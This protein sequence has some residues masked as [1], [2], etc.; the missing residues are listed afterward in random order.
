MKRLSI[1][2][3]GVLL[4]IGLS[5]CAENP[6]YTQ[7]VFNDF[8]INP[9]IA[10]THDY[11]QIRSVDRFQWIGVENAPKT[12]ILSA[13][14]PHKSQ[15]M[16]W[17]G[18]LYLDTQGPTQTLGGYG[19][20]GYNITLKDDIHLSF[21]L[22]FGIIQYS[23]D[24]NKID[25]LNEPE[26]LATLSSNKY[27]KWTPDA[28][29]GTYLY[30]TQYYAGVSVDQLFNNKI[31]IERVDS[32]FVKGDKALNRLKSNFVLF[33]GYKFN[34]NRDF[35]MEPSGLFRATGRTFPQVEITAKAIY[36]KMAW[37][38]VTFRSSDA[39]ALLIGYNYKDQIYVGY[40]Y[41]ITWSRIRLAS[42]GSHELMIGA[43]FNKIRVAAQPKL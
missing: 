35:D 26:E 7:Y 25:F 19:S 10:G 3:T 28:T 24:M 32:S 30:A 41:D 29:I 20:Y 2:W 13:Y 42:A 12:Y 34:I 9:A 31:D 33:G 27:T 36:Q 22:H 1:I 15:P 16:G 43:K 14:G 21:G 18:Y 40:S 39:V 11:Y 17:G 6:L 38:A 4:L 8:I 23:I 37:L 5:V